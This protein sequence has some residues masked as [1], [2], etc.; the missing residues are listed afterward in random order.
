[1]KQGRFDLLGRTAVQPVGIGQ[2]GEATRT[3]RIRTMTLGTVLQ[4]QTLT[5]LGSIFVQG[6]VGYGPIGSAV[7]FIGQLTELGTK[8]FIGLDHFPLVLHQLALLTRVG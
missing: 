6:D 1:M 4:E 2:V 3:A 5:H 7:G 8:D